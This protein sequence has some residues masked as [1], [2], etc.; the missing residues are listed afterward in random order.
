[1]QQNQSRVIYGPNEEQIQINHI[2]S[3]KAV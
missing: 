2:K 3:V 1:M